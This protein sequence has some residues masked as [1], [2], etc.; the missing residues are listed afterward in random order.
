MARRTT[1]GERGRDTLRGLDQL[2]GKVAL[3]FVQEND[4]PTVRLR[5]DR[6]L[7][8]NP[9]TTP[10]GHTEF[11]EIRAFTC[12]TRHHTQDSYLP[13]KERL[14]PWVKISWCP[15]WV[16]DELCARF[17]SRRIWQSVQF[18][19]REGR[20]QYPVFPTDVV[21]AWFRFL[22][23]VEKAWLFRSEKYLTGFT[24]EYIQSCPGIGA[25]L[26]TPD[27]YDKMADCVVV[28]HQ[29]D[30]DP[31]VRFTDDYPEQFP[32]NSQGPIGREWSVMG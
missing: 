3:D 18:G 4:V 26:R 23:P 1:P 2:T 19:N 25:K 17:T 21:I 27:S 22:W 28:A 31:I 7:L 29:E 12:R 16:K 11:N 24:E 6:C 8:F 10:R 13:A 14:Y 30:G 20:E 9:Y 15:Q 32:L 5:G